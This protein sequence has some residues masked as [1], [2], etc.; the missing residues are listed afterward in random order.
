MCTAKRLGHN[1]INNAK[2]LHMGR[3][4]TQ[5]LGGI[6]CM[7]AAAPKNGS[8]A[9]WRDHR[10]DCMLEHHHAVAS[11]KCNRAAGT[12]LTNDAGHHRGWQ[13][14]AGA[15]CCGDGLG[16]TTLFG[17]TPRISACRINKAQHRQAK[18]SGKFHQTR[19]LAIAFG[20]CHAEIALDTFFGTAALFRTHDHDSLTAEPRHAA[21]DRIILGIVSITR[22]R[23]EIIK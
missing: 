11:G 2:F 1:G 14:Q 18:A 7:I 12:T 3:S 10:I 21:N 22:Q 13:A 23:R 16:L 9:F 20:A 5:R 4:D 19:C 6:A 15:D 8:A 17:T